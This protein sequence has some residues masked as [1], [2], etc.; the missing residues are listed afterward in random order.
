MN[1]QRGRLSFTRDIASGIRHLIDSRAPYGIYNL[2]NSGAPSTWADIAADVFELTGGHRDDVSGVSTA[3]YFKDKH[4]APRPLNSVL[5][6]S[7]VQEVGFEPEDASKR[8]R[9]YLAQG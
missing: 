3:E 1:D 5:D 2:S 8:L 7:R 6:L 9:E 4:A